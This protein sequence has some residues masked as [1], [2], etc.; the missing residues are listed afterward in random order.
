MAGNVRRRSP[1]WAN[2]AVVVEL[3]HQPRPLSLAHAAQ[4]LTLVS[5]HSIAS[6]WHRA[7]VAAQ[8]KRKRQ[9][10]GVGE[11]LQHGAKRGHRLGMVQVQVCDEHERQVVVRF[12]VRAEK[13]LRA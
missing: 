7:E 11:A 1:S 2:M 9:K 3:S 10:V 12:F 6:V 5:A 4:Q 13:R 8:H